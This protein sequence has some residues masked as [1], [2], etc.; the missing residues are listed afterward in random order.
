M[1]ARRLVNLLPKGT[2]DHLKG[3]RKRLRLAYV[4]RWHGF[5]TGDLMAAL[6]RLGVR[7]GDVLLVHSSYDRFAGFPGKPSDV[8]RVLQDAVGATGTVL[9][10][11]LPFTGTA[12]DY[13]AR[14]SIFDV[15]RTPSQ[16]GLL[17]EL[18]R[19]S[20]EVSRSVHPT[21]PVAAWGART[22]E[23]LANHHLARTPCG[24]G[25]PFARLLEHDGRILLLG[26]DIESM[27]F[28]HYLEEVLEPGMP[29]SPFT[30]EEFSLESRDETGAILVSKTRLF[31]PALSRRRDLRKLEPVLRQQGKWAETR[32]GELCII[33]LEARDVMAASKS[34]A[35]QGVYCYDG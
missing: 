2:K 9:M 24:E 14:G 12:V 28:F 10:P 1:S 19:R 16:V 8:I 25:T 26:A 34:L 7:S 31:D 22:T 17:T 32:L 6:R 27:T 21:H 29:K 13:A 11:T 23:M 5:G 18:F 3:W 15:R 30:M 4:R 35:A 20:P 33:L